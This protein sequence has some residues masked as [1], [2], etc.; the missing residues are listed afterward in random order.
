MPDHTRIYEH[1]AHTYQQ[2]IS[3]QPSLAPIIEELCPY[4]GLDIIDLGAG[5]GRLTTVL[6]PEVRSII[7]LDASV[8]MLEVTAQRLQKAGLSGWSTIAADHRKLPLADGSADLIVSGWSICYLASSDLQDWR[9]NLTDVM[10][11]IE[12]VIRPNGTVI[13]LETMGTG[14]ETPEPPSF[15]KAY[16]AALEEDY[17]FS[18]RWIR[19]DYRFDDAAQTEALTRFFFGDALADRVAEQQLVQVPECAGIWWKQF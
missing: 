13:I 12:R 8:A 6:A 16:Y 2:L 18:H 11:E 4:Q 17:G 3:K 7:A 1:E 14:V 19:M 9:Q 10:S 15:L 5:T